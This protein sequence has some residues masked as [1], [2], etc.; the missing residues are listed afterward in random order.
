MLIM[1]ALALVGCQGGGGPPRTSLCE[2]VPGMDTDQLA[3]CGC[4]SADTRADQIPLASERE[5]NVSQSVS[6]V[7]YMCPMGSA[8][9]A[10]VSVLNGIAQQIFY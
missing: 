4:V 3:L 5:R 1:G 6:M 10:Q 7:N 2:L 9:V 8:G